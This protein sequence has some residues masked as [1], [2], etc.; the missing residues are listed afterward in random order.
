MRKLIFFYAIKKTPCKFSCFLG[1]GEKD[2]EK[3][4]CGDKLVRILAYCLMPTHVHLLVEQLEDKGI[5]RFINLVL[6]SYSAYFN[7]KHKRRGPLWEGRFKNVLVD[8]DDKFLHL[9]R[10]I[11]LNPVSASIVERPQDWKFSSFDDYM[12]ESNL[13]GS[14]TC[15]F[16]K[17][18]DMRPED[19]K[20]FVEDRID[21]Q[22]ML[23]HIKHLTIE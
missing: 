9:T 19:Y 16:S 17:Y 5:S 23:E 13:S 3:R 6:K 2:F 4:I 18:I 22:R 10:Y 12:K 11:H 8:T 21:Y 7:L 15:E 14:M 1:S 20:K